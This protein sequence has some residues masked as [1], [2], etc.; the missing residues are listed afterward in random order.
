MTR[1]RG[2]TLKRGRKGSNPFGGYYRKGARIPMNDL[3]TNFLSHFKVC[4]DHCTPNLFRV[5][6]IVDILNKR[7][8]LKLIK[9]DINLYI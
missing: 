7:L 9:H 2:N 6:S 4:P 8:G 3:L 1:V 5:V